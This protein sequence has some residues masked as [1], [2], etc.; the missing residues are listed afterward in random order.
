MDEDKVLRVIEKTGFT[1]ICILGIKDII[2]QEVPEAVAQC[3]RAGIIVRMVTGDN[4]VTAKAIALECN[5][6]NAEN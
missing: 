6:I 4:K 1:L 3:Q 5:I 2:R